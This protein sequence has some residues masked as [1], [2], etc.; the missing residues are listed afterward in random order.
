M[1]EKGAEREGAWIAHCPLFD[2]GNQFFCCRCQE[3]LYFQ[4]CRTCSN[5]VAPPNIICIW[6]L[7]IG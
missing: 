2:R 6:G 1:G 5:K 7:Q 4:P 3:A